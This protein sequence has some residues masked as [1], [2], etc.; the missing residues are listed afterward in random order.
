MN[1]GFMASAQEGVCG[2]SLA[3]SSARPWVV[4]E[5]VPA[6][7]GA[8]CSEYRRDSLVRVARSQPVMRFGLSP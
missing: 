8:P 5:G 6:H 4:R 3:V 7:A 2:P 1:D